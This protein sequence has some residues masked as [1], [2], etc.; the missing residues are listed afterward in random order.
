MED[1]DTDTLH[2]MM[3]EADASLVPPSSDF[4]ADVLNSIMDEV[5]ASI[6]HQKSKEV[7]ARE[8]EEEERAFWAQCVVL[9]IEAEAQMVRGRKPVSFRSPVSISGFGGGAQ[10]VR[11]PLK[12][13]QVHP[14]GFSSAAR[15]LARQMSSR[16][17]S[18]RR[19][20]RDSDAFDP[21]E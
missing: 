13:H 19:S 21:I 11:M 7:E 5:E 8:K 4:E 3:D 2:L 10:R 18:V 6:V 9:T 16:K 1:F 17:T 14:P 20:R 12:S 15:G